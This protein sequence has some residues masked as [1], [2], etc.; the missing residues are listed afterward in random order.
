MQLSDRTLGDWLEFWAEKT[1]EKEIGK[2]EQNKK[3]IL[4][5]FK[6]F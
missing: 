1:P 2:Y 6:Q 4:K 5:N 3:T